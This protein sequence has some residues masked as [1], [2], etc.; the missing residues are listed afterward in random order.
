MTIPQQILQV[1]DVISALLAKRSYK[2]EYPYD[3]IKEILDDNINNNKLNK[4]IIEI[5]YKYHEEISNEANEVI[6]NGYIIK[7][8]ILKERELLYKK[9]KDFRAKFY[10]LP[11][12]NFAKK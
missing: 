5:F 1:S 6:L 9:N 10:N 11:L 4:D 2:E 8:K 7:E 12:S 3:K